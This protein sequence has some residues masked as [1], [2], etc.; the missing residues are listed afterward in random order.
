[1][2]IT[3]AVCKKELDESLPEKYGTSSAGW[4]RVSKS[5]SAKTQI[6]RVFHHRE[7][8]VQGTV[9]E[10]DSEITQVTYSPLVEETETFDSPA[11]NEFG[12]A[13]QYLFAILNSEEGGVRHLA[14]CPVEFWQKNRCMSD[15][16][17]RRTMEG[18]LPP[19]CEE[20]AEGFF[21]TAMKRKELHKALTAR[22]FK[23]DPHFTNFVADLF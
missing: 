12:S 13:D 18:L 19:G 8:A 11:S 14:I 5:G 9:I 17:T 21:Q 3:T 6:V 7:L 20:E 10:E 22:G 1:M 2:K 23:E 15:S 16:L 4:K